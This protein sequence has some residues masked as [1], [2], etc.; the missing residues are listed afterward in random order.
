MIH[1]DHTFLGTVFLQLVTVKENHHL[2]RLLWRVFF[3]LHV[4]LVSLGCVSPVSSSKAVDDSV[5][6]N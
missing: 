1:V 3:S 6:G 4:V 2:K 5:T